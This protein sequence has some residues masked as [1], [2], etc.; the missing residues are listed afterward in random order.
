MR[1]LATGEI[2]TE[3]VNIVNRGYIENITDGII[4]EV[5]TFVDSFGLH[6]Q[7]I[8]RLPEGIAA[9]CDALGREYLLAVEA[10]ITGDKAKAL[11]AFMLDPLCANCEYP[12]RLL[13]E[14]L[15]DNASLLPAY[16]NL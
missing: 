16:W 15:T 6:P 9:K 5:P 11:Q 7:K 2:S 12:E 3:M 4:V 13:E 1:S 14:L 8:G 10:A